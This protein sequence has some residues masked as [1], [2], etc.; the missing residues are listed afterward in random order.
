[1]ASVRPIAVSMKD[2]DVLLAI[3]GEIYSVESAD[4]DHL[5]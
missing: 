1:M 4:V 2:F 3:V 5:R